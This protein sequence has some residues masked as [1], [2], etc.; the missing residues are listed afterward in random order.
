T[1]QNAAPQVQDLSQKVAVLSQ[2]LKAADDVLKTKEQAFQQAK[3]QANRVPTLTEQQYQLESMKSKLVEK[4]ELDSAIA[5]G[6]QQKSEF[7][8]TL[9]KYIVFREKLTQDALQAQKVL[10]QARID[11]ASIGGV[12]AEI[13]QQQ[14]LMSDLQKLANLNQELSKLG[15]LTPSKQASVTQAKSYYE[16]LQREAD[17][18]ELSWHNAQAAVLALRLQT[19]E[20]CPVCGSTEHPQPAQFVG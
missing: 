3:E 4:V 5:A 10:E 11:V 8:E 19:G 1:L 15:A 2:D 17:A 12:D 9:K 14:R 18:L 16:N 6:L 13:K 7:E 20:K